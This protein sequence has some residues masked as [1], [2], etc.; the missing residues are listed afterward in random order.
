MTAIDNGTIHYRDEVVRKLIH[1]CSIS[2]PI[3]YYYIPRNN[4]LLIL[5]IVTF[6]AI[7]V[8]LLR[9]F[10]PTFAKLFYSFFG[11]LLRKH[12]K[13]VKIKTLNGASYVLISATICVFIFP[14]I[15]VVTAFGILIIS[16]TLAALIGRKF[17]KHK[18]LKKSFEGTLAFFLSA[19]VVVIA[20]PKITGNIYE[21]LIGFIA[22]FIGAIVEN[23]SFGWI[24]DNLSIPI[25]IGLVMW[26]LYIIFLP[27]VALI[28]PNVPR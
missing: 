21:Y 17:G 26:L 24:D 28:L 22:C 20:T 9:Y 1:L 14:K 2:I 11:F 13:D 19:I 23:I 25:S 4:A 3:V 6:F 10:L 5:L 7:I 16:D 12:E 15:F 8:D 18:L 27:N